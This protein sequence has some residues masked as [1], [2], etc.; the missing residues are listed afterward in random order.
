MHIIIVGFLVLILFGIGFTSNGF[1]ESEKSFLTL[2]SHEITKTQYATEVKK[3]TVTGYVSDYERGTVMHLF[4]VSPT[5]E[6][7]KFNTTGTDDGDFFTI[8]HIDGTFET[9]EYR[10]MLEYDGKQIAATTYMII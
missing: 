10:L 2:D 4:N 5:G 1:S 6:M 3:L 9:G 8:I 7:T